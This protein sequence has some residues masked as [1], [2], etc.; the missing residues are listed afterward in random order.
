M[1][2]WWRGRML[3]FDLETTSPLPEEARIVTAGISLVGGGEETVLRDWLI[4]PEGFEIPAEATEIH[5]VSQELAVAEGM[6]VV[7]ALGEILSAILDGT[8]GGVPLVV[9]NAPYDCTVLDRELRRHMAGSWADDLWR[10]G[11][12]RPAVVVDPATIDRHLDRFRP[13]RVAAHSLEGCCQVWDAVVDRV[14]G[15][16]GAS[17][18]ALAACRLAFRLGQRGQVRRRVRNAEEGR[19]RARLVRE[20]EQVRGDLT[21]LHAA[22]A[23]W[24]AERAEDYERY[25]RAGDPGRDVLPEPDRV[26]PRGWP[27]IEWWSAV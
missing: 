9:F 24:F 25:V 8:D 2:E 6:P 5:G 19:E 14:D 7:D 26:I 23:R 27:M 15:V 22:Q 1:A 17:V 4:R 12:R 13:K 18:D 21:Q 16:H 3:G 10:P 20:W 11:E